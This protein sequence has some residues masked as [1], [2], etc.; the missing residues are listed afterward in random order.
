MKK[1]LAMLFS[2]ALIVVQAAFMSGAAEF[3]P[4]KATIPKCCGHCGHCKDKCCVAQNGS[5]APLSLPA[6]PSQSITQIDWQLLTAGAGEFSAQT[7]AESPTIFSRISS[8]P[9]VTAPLY[10]RNCSYLI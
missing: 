2:V 7:L 1:L 9:S 5:D 10:Q 3:G 6:V 4:Q 8:H